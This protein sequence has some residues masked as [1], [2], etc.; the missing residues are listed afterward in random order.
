[1]RGER[2]SG[3]VVVQ[4]VS[5]RERAVEEARQAVDVRQYLAAGLEPAGQ[6]TPPPLCSSPPTSPASA[7]HKDMSSAC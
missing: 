3:G 4:R 7:S 2:A 5:H 1:M 6:R